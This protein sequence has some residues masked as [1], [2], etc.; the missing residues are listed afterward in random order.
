MAL[1][2]ACAVP[3]LHNNYPFTYWGLDNADHFHERQGKSEKQKT[4]SYHFPSPHKA[5][6]PEGTGLNL[7]ML[8]QQQKQNSQHTV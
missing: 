7:E 3:S 8:A 4:H 5:R 6:K 2:S 1:G